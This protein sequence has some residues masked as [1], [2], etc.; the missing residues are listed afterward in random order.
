MAKRLLVIIDPQNDSTHWEGNDARRHGSIIQIAET[1]ARIHSLLN[2]FA[3]NE[4]VIVRSSYQPDQFGPGLSMCIPNT[5]G[6][7]IDLDLQVDGKSTMMTK[8]EHS[9]FSS[10]EFRGLLNTGKID[11]LILCGFLA[12]YCVKQTAMDALQL[13]YNVVLVEDCIATGDDV[14]QRKQQVLAELKGKGALLVASKN[15]Y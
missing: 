12:E 15:L 9:C 2:A 11:T 3:G 5:F 13:E 8:T 1:K 14:Q 7:E 4:T 10:K 6:H